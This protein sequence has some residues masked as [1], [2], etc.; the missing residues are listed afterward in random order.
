MVKNS[1]PRPSKIKEVSAWVRAAQSDAPQPQCLKS[2]LGNAQPPPPLSTLFWFSPSRRSYERLSHHW[3][4]G[5]ARG[6]LTLKFRRPVHFLNDIENSLKTDKNVFQHGSENIQI[7]LPLSRGWQRRRQHRIQRWLERPF[8]IRGKNPRTGWYVR[9]F[10][11]LLRLFLWFFVKCAVLR[12]FYF[13]AII[14]F[15]HFTLL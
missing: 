4:G 7:H 2:Q 8:Q 13:C 12:V 6:F 11:V 3:P 10:V 1:L 5:A 14:F 15:T 9:V